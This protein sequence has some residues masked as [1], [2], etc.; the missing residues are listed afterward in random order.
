MS[1]MK[2]S[3]DSMISTL[4]ST[5]IDKKDDMRVCPRKRKF[6]EMMQEELQFYTTPRHTSAVRWM[7]VDG[8]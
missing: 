6:E 4:R 5:I 3:F 2:D 8:K 1:Q 7:V